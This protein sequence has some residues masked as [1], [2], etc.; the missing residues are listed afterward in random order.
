MQVTQ[1]FWMK[2]IAHIIHNF[3]TKR[4]L[5]SIGVALMGIVN[6][7]SVLLPSLPGRLDLLTNFFS[8]LA[9][10]TPSAWSFIHIGRT[11]S[12]ILGLYLLLLAFGLARGK[13]KARQLALIILPL[14]ALTHLAKGLD[15]EEAAVSMALWL[16]LYLNKPSF[17]VESD[18]YQM[19]QGIILL[20][21]GFALIL[22]YS[23]VGFYF[24]QAQ[25]VPHTTFGS[26]LRSS[27]KH[28]SNLPTH[29][30][31][32]L[33]AKATWFL[34]SILW[35]SVAALLTGMFF[36]LRPV[37][38][39]WWIAFQQERLAEAR[40]K[41]TDLL[42]RYGNQAHSFFAFAPENLRY[43][44][45]DGEGMIPYRL[46]NNV[47]VILGDP[48]CAPQ[49]CQWIMH[50]FLDLCQREDWQVAIFQA[51]P[52]KLPVYRALGLHFFK[53][54]EEAIVNP[55][56]FTLSGSALANVRCSARRA[57]RDGVSIRWYEG[58]PPEDVLNQLREVSSNWLER[59]A[60]RDAMEMGFSMGRLDE[61]PEAA[62]RADAIADRMALGE[63]SPQVTPRL[64]T[65]VA[66]EHNGRVCAFATF[67]PI[68]GKKTNSCA[69]SVHNT[70]APGCG[71]ALDLMRRL[72]DAPP[73][74]MEL[75]IV[76][77]IE[78]AR[79][80]GAEVLSLGVV[81]MA[82]MNEEMTVKQRQIASFL[83]EHLHLLETHRSLLRF[84]QKFHPKWESRYM[85][86]SSTLALPKVALA[87]LK[88]HL[89]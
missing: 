50:R 65:G 13:Q 32:P 44:A 30:L 42:Y 77:A 24:L 88:A 8:Q 46:M 84:K 67:T 66:T 49:A 59:K 22:L 9:P 78:R 11:T 80:R 39:G 89:S 10:F 27:L 17:C 45:P 15:V 41:A 33:T 29:E 31:T 83:V 82:D 25:F 68:Y 52:E 14:S 85:V 48:L 38:T 4:W 71:W 87:I 54:G 53:I 23:M 19:R 2:I 21:V 3:Q 43:L 28:M 12:L 61:L 51:H 34:D 76:Q 7:L 16:A 70:R 69:T 58:P 81:A 56:F 64:M 75:L 55:Q 47:A 74:V 86:A 36:L 57:E 35:L 60:G 40:E 20:V 63:A 1:L 79:K 6:G 62:A 18:P 37:S 26:A 5:L 73:G 72:P